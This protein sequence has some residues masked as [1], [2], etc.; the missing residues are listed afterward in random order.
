MEKEIYEQPE[1]IKRTLEKSSEDIDHIVSEIE[2]ETLYLVGSGS[3]YYCGRIFSYIYENLTGKKAISCYAMEFAKYIRNIVG[4]KDVVFILSQSGETYDAINAAAGLENVIAVT[5]T[6]S[7]TITKIA[8]HTIL[9]WAGK[10]KAVPSTKTF[11]SMLSAL[12]LYAA[13]ETKN[14][15]IENRLFEISQILRKTLDDCKPAAERIGKHLVREQ[16]I[17]IIGDGINY[18]VTLESALKMKETAIMHA[19][20]IP[21]AEYFHGHISLV[22]EGYPIFLMATGNE[23]EETTKRVIERLSVINAY[24]PVFAFEGADISG[25]YGA[26]TITLSNVEKIL[27]PFLSIPIV[28][29]IAFNTAII[30]GVNPDLPRELTKVVM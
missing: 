4:P 10:E 11:T 9:T 12:T 30:K 8:K 19:Q 18:P 27:S 16:V 28:H 21:L 29:L 22:S 17:D 3:S 26:P 2:P 24:V 13:R 5:N 15:S 25:L 20:G 1:A 14:I 6:E 23:E 7:S